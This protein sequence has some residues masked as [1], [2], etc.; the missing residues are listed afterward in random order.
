MTELEGFKEKLTPGAQN[1]LEEAIEESKNR[2]HYYLGVE[3]LFL[4][5]AKVEEGF[6]R[7]IMNEL[8]LDSYHVLNF[9]S[10]HLSISRQY[11]GVGLKVPPATKNIFRLAREE[12]QRWGREEID[13]TDLFLAIF[14]ENHS[15]PAKIF[16]SFGLDPDFVMRTI[17]VKVR[18]KEEQE[19]EIKKKYELPPNLK[20][21]AVNLNKL[22]RYDKLP[23][24]IGRDP[25]IEQVL[26]ILCHVERSNSVMIVGEPGV[27]KTAVVE[28]LARTIELEPDRV[29]KRLRDK[30]IVN[31]QMNSVVAGTIFRG[32]FEDR[33]EKIIKEIKQRKNIIFFVD[34][35]HTLIG[36]GS[37]MGVPSDAANI[38]KSTL[39]RGEVQIIGATTFAEYKEFIAEDE[40][41]A[42]RFRLVHVQEPSLQETKEILYGIRPRLERNYSVKITD[43]AVD[44]A[45]DMS[46]R[47]MRSLK[48]P[49]KAIGWLDTSCVKVEINRP[50]DPVTTD[51][52]VEVIS[53]ETKIP[54]DMIFRDTTTR[55]KEMEGALSGR[56]VGQKEAIEALS[57]RLRL[58]KGPLKEN[59]SRP[60]GVL[61]FLGPTGVGKTEL[62]KALAEFLFGDDKK[63]IRVDMSE[64]KDSGVAV[65]KLIGMPRGIVGSERGGILTNQVRENPYSVVLLDEVEKAHPYV[66]NLFLQVFDEGWLTDGRGKRV[67]FSDTVIILTSNLGS[68]EF[69]KFLKPMGFLPDG[70]RI[71]TL[72]KGITKEVERTFSPE[73]LNRIDDIIVFSP[74]TRD[75]V[76]SITRMYL[77]RIRGHMAG[78]GKTLSITEEAVEKLVEEGYSQKYGARFLKRVVDDRVKTPVT[79]KWKEGVIFNI[80]VKDGALSVEPSPAPLPA[81]V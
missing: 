48:L 46:Q 35:A 50:D 24:I 10:E 55:F 3:H 81:L 32:M 20:H 71:G 51:D 12:A 63:M 69:T 7:D 6:F 62:A 49:D 33:I 18:S 2:Q 59:F 74:L 43:E 19:E 65:D 61:L 80:D 75:E 42:R 29:P 8:N 37:A 5:F 27:G 30:Q 28:G 67:Y 52:V 22:A 56:V 73:F 25:E 31:L 66:I 58:N 26:E 78:Y 4:A 72:K 47:Y 15:L 36:A 76:C 21:F 16:R 41:L 77:D 34:E 23:T 64:Y 39:S 68:D 11:I 17:T 70:Q 53:Q 54:K 79:L 40:A 14:Q 1:V 45:L 57:K 9:L 38:F 60:D 44:T 13:S